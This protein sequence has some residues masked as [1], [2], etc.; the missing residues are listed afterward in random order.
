V[1]AKPEVAV[2]VGVGLARAL[3]L[4]PVELD[5]DAAVRPEAVDRP[6]A[7]GL[8]AQRELDPPADEE[9]AEPALEPALRLSVAG[10]VGV[11]RGPEVGAAGMAAAERAFDVGRAQVVVEL[12]FR[13]R[14]QEGAVVVAGREVEERAGDGGG[15]EAAVVGGVVRAEAAASV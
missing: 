1:A 5:R 6:R 4:A 10:R 14:A 3:V 15:G 9:G 2:V 11:Q 7:D 8:V 12:G 13:E